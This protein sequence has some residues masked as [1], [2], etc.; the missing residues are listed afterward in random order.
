MIPAQPN[1]Y[2]NEQS[3]INYSI[4]QWDKLMTICRAAIVPLICPVAKTPS[5]PTP[6]ACP[7]LLT[8]PLD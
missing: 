6:S 1:D 5:P 2:L 8:S 7:F 3:V 4:R